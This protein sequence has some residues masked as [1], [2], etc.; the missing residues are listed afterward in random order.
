MPSKRGT[1]KPRLCVCG[2]GQIA[3]GKWNK[4][5]GQYATYIRGHSNALRSRKPPKQELEHQYLG[6]DK[7]MEEVGRHY[8]VHQSTVHKWI[9]QYGIKPKPH[10]RKGSKH[11][12]Y[13][14]WTLDGHGYLVHRAHPHNGRRQHRLVA[15]EMLGRPLRKDE[16][17]H[18]INGDKTDNRPE[19][20]EIIDRTEHSLLSLMELLPTLAERYPHRISA[21]KDKINIL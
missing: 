12:R 9:H 19:N 2:C 1:A 7:S 10:S 3:P 21:L 17:V 6:L 8:G 16:V 13:K 14:G 5:S 15:E 20:L 4:N 18:H 11:P